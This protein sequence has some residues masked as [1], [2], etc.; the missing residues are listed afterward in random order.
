MAEKIPLDQPTR[1]TI[2]TLFKD[3]IQRSWAR[4]EIDPLYL[5]YQ[6]ANDRADKF[7]EELLKN[8][9]LKRLNVA[10]EKAYRTWYAKDKKIK[11]QAII[12]RRQYLANGITPNLIKEL[13]KLL[14]CK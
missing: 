1:R 7:E 10:K 6:E 3:L 13:N 11:E 9:T 8:K 4:D 2:E 12:L 5:K 14:G